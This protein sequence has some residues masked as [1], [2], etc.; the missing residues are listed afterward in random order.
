[1]ANAITALAEIEEGALEETG[2][3][4]TVYT[5]DSNT[6][7]KLLVALGECTE[8]GRIALLTAIASYT[9]VDE[10]EAKVGCVRTGVEVAGAAPL[11][12]AAVVEASLRGGRGGA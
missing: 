4:G 1:M 2:Q 9:A 5:L 3:H 11:G 6:I 12:D 7:H 10:K 8:W